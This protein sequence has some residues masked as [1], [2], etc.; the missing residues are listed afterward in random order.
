MGFDV[1]SD[2][3]VSYDVT[4][5]R[6]GGVDIRTWNPDSGRFTNT[7]STGRGVGA[8]PLPAWMTRLGGALRNL[9]GRVRDLFRGG[10][11]GGA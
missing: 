10:R 7:I 5:N 9:G 1:L 2:S 11:Q 3:G 8:N 6:N 4:R